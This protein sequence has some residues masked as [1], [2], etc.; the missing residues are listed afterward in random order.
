MLGFPKGKIS[1]LSPT[2]SEMLSDKDILF[3]IVNA[4]DAKKALDKETFGL[5][6]Q[7]FDHFSHEKKKYPA[8]SLQY[9]DR[10]FSIAK[11]FE[12]NGVPYGLIC[13]DA[14]DVYSMFTEKKPVFDDAAWEAADEYQ[15]LVNVLVDRSADNISP[16]AVYC[17]AASFM[18]T[19]FYISMK[20][21][22]LECETEH[23]R[24]MY[25]AILEYFLDELKGLYEESYSPESFA[26]YQSALAASLHPSMNQGDSLHVFFTTCAEQ[27]MVL[28]G[29][30][31]DSQAISNLVEFA[32]EWEKIALTNSNI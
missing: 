12:D 30:E 4:M 5:F 22:G 27:F 10:A 32:E 16:Y 17:Y 2:H 18:S 21:Y 26:K 24:T 3:N 6:C 23:A 13:G 19:V 20:V 7:I 25:G 11:T 28:I 15:S 14:Y 9:T 1:K 8:N 31:D 29:N